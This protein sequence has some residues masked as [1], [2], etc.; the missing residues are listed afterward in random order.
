M[1]DADEVFYKAMEQS[2][3]LAQLSQLSA[4]LNGLEKGAAAIL[5][6][7]VSASNAVRTGKYRV[8]SRQLSQRIIR[9]SLNT[10][11]PARSNIATY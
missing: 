7:V 4:V 3:S 6:H 1:R 2:E 8:D 5:S 10:A 11:V 9:D